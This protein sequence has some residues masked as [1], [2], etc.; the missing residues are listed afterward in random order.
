MKITIEKGAPGYRLV[1]PNGE[2]GE[3]AEY[4]E[5]ATLEIDGALYFA[6]LPSEEEEFEELGSSVFSEA[7]CETEVVEVDFEEDDEPEEVGA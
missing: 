5:P 6:L 7:D 2:E 4:G 3:L 1:G